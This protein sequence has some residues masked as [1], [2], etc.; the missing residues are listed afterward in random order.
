MGGVDG[1]AEPSP[2]RAVTVNS[3]SFMLK[4]MWMS[5]LK[6]YSVKDWIERAQNSTATALRDEA[7]CPMYNTALTGDI[8]TQLHVPR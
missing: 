3:E 4:K 1:A 8:T 2:A 5:T 7:R 6:V